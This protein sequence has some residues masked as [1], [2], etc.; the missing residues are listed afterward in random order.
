[1]AKHLPS[2]YV[3]TPK[4]WDQAP[5]QAPSSVRSQLLPLPPSPHPRSWAISLK[6]INEILFKNTGTNYFPLAALG[7]HFFSRDPNF[8]ISL[9]SIFCLYGSYPALHALHY[10]ENFSIKT[11]CVIFFPVIAPTLI[12]LSL[13]CDL[14]FNAR[15]H[16]GAHTFL[17]RWGGHRN[18]MLWSLNIENDTFK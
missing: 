13:F 11:I 10:E 12:F 1:M 2:A 8:L 3:M 16:S 6:R 5:N 4:S 15:M 14:Y 17:R 18:L 7:L 9:D